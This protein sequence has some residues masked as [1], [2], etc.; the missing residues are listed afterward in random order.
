MKLLSSLFAACLVATSIRAQ[1]S[2]IPQPASVKQPKDRSKIQHHYVYS[3]RIR[4]VGTRN[5]QL[6]AFVSDLCA[7][8]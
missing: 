2:I 4:K 7:L 6:A 1:I 5:V 3:N 8:A